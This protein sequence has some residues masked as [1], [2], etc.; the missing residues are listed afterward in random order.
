MRWSSW[1]CMF[2]VVCCETIHRLRKGLAFTPHIP[3]F[4]E[5]LGCLPRSAESA[6]AC[7]E[8][9]SARPPSARALKTSLA[10][11]VALRDSVLQFINVDALEAEAALIDELSTAPDFWTDAAAAN[12]LLQRRADMHRQLAQI[13]RW[14]VLEEDAQAAVDLLEEAPTDTTEL[15]V[16]AASCVRVLRDDVAAMYR[17]Q[18]I[19]MLLRSLDEGIHYS[20][21]DGR[22]LL[23][24]A[25]VAAASAAGLLSTSSCH[26][27]W[28]CIQERVHNRAEVKRKYMNYR[29]K[30]CGAFQRRYL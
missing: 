23:T 28:E 13:R 1:R 7:V 16:E 27:V 29:C 26:H 2:A 3:V 18:S 14:A 6:D 15:A 30:K 4:A 24:A 22:V 10:E 9:S 12:K 8:E 11:A 20:I 17:S 25:G 19:N 21:A 5:R